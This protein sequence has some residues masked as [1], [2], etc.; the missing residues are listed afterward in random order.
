MKKLL[1]TLAIVGLA[2][3]VNAQ[4]PAGDAK[5]GEWYGEKVTTDGPV[6]LT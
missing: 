6:A 4:P 2:F 3:I 5:V 1:F